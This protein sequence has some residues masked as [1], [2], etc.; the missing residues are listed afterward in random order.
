MSSVKPLQG[1][2]PKPYAPAE[3]AHISVRL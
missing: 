3:V 2:L 1:V